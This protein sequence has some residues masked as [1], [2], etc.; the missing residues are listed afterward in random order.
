MQ[1]SVEFIQ[2][3]LREQWKGAASKKCQLLV[4]VSSQARLRRLYFKGD[5][6][7]GESDV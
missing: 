1:I 5:G 2:E 7:E 6:G 4:T 3:L